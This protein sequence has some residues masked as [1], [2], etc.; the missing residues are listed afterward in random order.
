MRAYRHG[1][2]RACMH[3]WTRMVAV[4]NTVVH[5]KALQVVAGGC[6]SSLEATGRLEIHESILNLIQISSKDNATK[7]IGLMTH[8][9]QLNSLD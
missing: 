1:W 7:F 2:G 4:V 9:L 5:V 3:A 6:W 8:D